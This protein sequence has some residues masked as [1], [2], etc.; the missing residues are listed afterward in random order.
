MEVPFLMPFRAIYT[1]T[2]Y[3][4]YIYSGGKIEGGSPLD[5]SVG[6][7]VRAAYTR[8]PLTKRLPVTPLLAARFLFIDLLSRRRG[9]RLRLS[10]SLSLSLSSRA[11]SRIKG[12]FNDD[13][14]ENRC[15]FS[16][17]LPPLFPSLSGT[18]TC[19][20][21]EFHNDYY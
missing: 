6:F 19:A 4:C 18:G 2:T 5:S 1:S 9:P 13:L 7:I 17:P 11:L 12:K 15:D 16:I 21:L 8:W 20:N 3:S 14:F 10:L